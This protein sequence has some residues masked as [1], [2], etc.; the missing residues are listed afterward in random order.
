MKT[1]LQNVFYRIFNNVFNIA[2]VKSAF[3]SNYD[4]K[5]K[6]QTMLFSQ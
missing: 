4:D 5:I 6:A 1:V 2:C 3:L